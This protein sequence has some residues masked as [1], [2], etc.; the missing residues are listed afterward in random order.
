MHKPVR[1]HF[2]I[3]RAFV[4]GIDFQWQDDLVDLG[5]VTKYNDCFR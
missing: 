5:S 2:E 1:Y 3:N 4:E